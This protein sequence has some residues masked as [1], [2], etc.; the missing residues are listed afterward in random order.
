MQALGVA[1]REHRVEA[2]KKIGIQGIRVARLRARP[3]N[4]EANRIPPPRTDVSRVADSEG[5]AAAT[6]PGG[7]ARVVYYV[8]AH[9]GPVR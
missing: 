6:V 5:R 7:H 2:R 1:Q 3:H 8:A 4:S 9:G